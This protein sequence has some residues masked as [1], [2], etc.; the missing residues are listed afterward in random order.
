MPGYDN[1]QKTRDADD[2]GRWRFAAEI[3]EVIRSTPPDWSARIGIFGKW[4]EGKSTILHFLEEILKPE[5]NIVFSFNPWAIQELDE[6]WAQFGRSLLE[7]LED[8]GL[9]AESSFKEGVRKLQGKLDDTPLA[10]M[11]ETAAELFG[12]AAIYKG[13]LGLVGRWLKPD[14]PQVKKIRE[15]LGDR[16]VIV[17]IDDLDRATP[18]LL[19]KLLLSLREILD[20]PGFTFV[21]AFDNEI[22]SGGLVTA[23]KAW[24]DGGN[25]L[26]KILDFHYYLPRV[27]E[28][29]KRCLLDKA[30]ERYCK[31]VPKE[32]LEPI[33]HLLPDNPR[34]LK[35]LVRSLVSLQPQL[36]RHGPDEL[37]WVEIWLAEMVRQESYP[38]F[39][40]LLEGDTLDTLVGI[41]Y[42][43]RKSTKKTT[44]QGEEDDHNDIKGI[45]GEV[46]GVSA[47]TQQRLIQLIEATRT[48]GGFSLAYNWRFADHPETITWMEFAELYTRWQETQTPDTILNWIREHSKKHSMS[49]DDIERELFETLLNAKQNEAAKAAELSTVKE[50]AIHCAKAE[51]LLKLTDHFLELP[52]T[53]TG[54]RFGKLYGQSLYWISFR[55]NQA[56]IKLRKAEKKILDRVT[57]RTP[58][59]Q[60][61]ALLDALE[62]WNSW[63]FA[64]E[65]PETFQL[66][67]ELRDRCVERILPKA[68]RALISYLS[69]PESI[70][71]LSSA[72]GSLAFRYIL[73]SP[74][75]APWSAALKKAIFDMMAHAKSDPNDFEKANDLLDF[76]ISGVEQRSPYLANEDAVRILADGNFSGILW[77]AAT[78]Q[79]I[80]FRMHGS[81][82]SKRSQLI[83][84]GVPEQN[85]P[86]TRELLITSQKLQATQPQK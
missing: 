58:D 41:R 78:S 57:K 4:G 83:G 69:R 61:P 14:G 36:A 8:A 25:F 39:K 77:S 67:Q 10:S 3:A 34:K 49:P 32:S 65:G 42:S 73:F 12:K 52:G 72:K 35:M 74:E 20:L 66:K 40:R 9:A 28:A 46:G 5:Q 11:S 50:N 81:Y 71:L 44:P 31:F 55:V 30:L 27:S 75:R 24:G 2:L 29:G 80:Q 15:T 7:A 54:E 82:L 53:L 86:L 13:A 56:D 85:L 68:E 23:N 38:F 18:E 70:R 1:A 19:P 60:A 47:D 63:A 22:V 37:N 43:V 64:P 17:L 62:P 16:R 26:D 33:E 6:L 21:L 48:L 76:L 45:I 51:M 84:L 59:V 79:Q